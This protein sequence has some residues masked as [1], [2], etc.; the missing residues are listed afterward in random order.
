MS[1]SRRADTGVF[2]AAYGRFADELYAEI[3][4]E[5]F[6]E[7]IG[8]TSWLTADEQRGFCSWLD[9]GSSSELLEVASGSGGPALFTVEETGCRVVGVDIHEEGVATAN[10]AARERGLAERARFLVVDAREQLPFDDESFDAVICIDS[11]NH[12]FDRAADPGGLA[13]RVTSRR[14]AVVHQ[15]RDVD[16]TRAPGGAHCAE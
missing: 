9:L 14:P 6:G 3:R 12:L 7:D 15:R 5:A 16:R 8:Q 4:R 13:S 2:D 11:I 10:T 1:E